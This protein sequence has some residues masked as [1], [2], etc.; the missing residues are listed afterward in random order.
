MSAIKFHPIKC[1][2]K[3]GGCK[4][5]SNHSVMLWL[6]TAVNPFLPTPAA[7][8]FIHFSFFF[9]FFSSSFTSF[10]FFL[11]QSPRPRVLHPIVSSACLPTQ[12]INRR[13]LC[14]FSESGPEKK[15]RDATRCSSFASSPF[16]PPPF[17]SRTSVS[18][19]YRGIPINQVR[20]SGY[21]MNIG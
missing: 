4:N 10:F 9:S 2:Q 7:C 12:I 15:G 6:Y 5:W 13:D 11:S 1:E 8:S 21:K 20:T 17:L 3:I 16:S 19:D 18:L 14:W